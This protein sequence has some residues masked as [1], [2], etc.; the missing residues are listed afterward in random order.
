MNTFSDNFLSAFPS[1]VVHHNEPRCI[2][3]YHGKMMTPHQKSVLI[4]EVK[5]KRT[6]QVFIANYLGVKPQR[7]WNIIADVKQGKIFRDEAHC[8][9]RIDDEGCTNLVAKIIAGKDDKE[10]YSKP[11]TYQL[12]KNEVAESDR[13]VGGKKAN[14]MTSS[15][16][17]NT[18]T[19]ILQEINATFEK[20][21]TT[22]KA[23]YRE[24]KDIR[25]MVS[26][27][28]M[29]EAFA[30]GKPPHLIANFDATQFVVTEKNGELL[31]TI[32]KKVEMTNH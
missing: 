7:I 19:K 21:Q 6:S 25:N 15:V 12:V 28:A 3:V 29:N 20:G 24:G 1:R 22:T 30:A 17:Y 32:K 10:P 9:S 2:D 4:E 13:R 18:S 11:E 14:G 23:R 8:P 16:S 27:A 5:S 31:V 26:M